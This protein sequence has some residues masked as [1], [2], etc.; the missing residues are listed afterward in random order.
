MPRA[1]INVVTKYI[2][3]FF[4]EAA[5]NTADKTF[6]AQRV[7]VNFYM[8]TKHFG[9]AVVRTA[10]HHIGTAFAADG[11]EMGPTLT[12]LQH[13]LTAMFLVGAVHFQLPYLS[14]LLIYASSV[15]EKSQY[16][17]S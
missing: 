8:F 6:W 12:D 17:D 13:T 10:Q 16:C 15:C 1:F 2:K 7:F 5:V 4:E 3:V 9:L 11:K 14:A